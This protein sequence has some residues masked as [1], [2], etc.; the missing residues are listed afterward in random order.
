M[1]MD[2][3]VMQQTSNMD[4]KWQA[5]WWYATIFFSLL[6][7][8]LVNRNHVVPLRWPVVGM[9]PALLINLHRLHDFMTSLL[10]VTGGTFMFEGP[11]FM[12]LDMMITCD[13]TNAKHMFTTHFSNYIKGPGRRL[14]GDIRHPRGRDHHRGRRKL[15]KAEKDGQRAHEKPQLPVL[16][17]EKQPRQ[18]REGSAASSREDGRPRPRLRPAGF[19][20]EERV[21]K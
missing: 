19:H 10:K 5:N 4:W 18:G 12:G 20:E 21:E 3:N 1:T 15:V 13:P 6:V 8:F 7:F 16:R 9:L 14:S 17:G 2:S 11:W